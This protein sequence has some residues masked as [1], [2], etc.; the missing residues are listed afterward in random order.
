VIGIAVPR[1]V[2]GL[3]VTRSGVTLYGTGT[4]R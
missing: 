2:T 3:R 4:G 1:T